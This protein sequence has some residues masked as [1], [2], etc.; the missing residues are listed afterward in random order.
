[1]PVLLKYAGVKSWSTF[2]RDMLLWDIKEDAGCFRIESNS[3]RPNGMWLEDSEQTIKFA[4]ETSVDIII[5]RVIV[6]LQDATRN[7]KT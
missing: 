7:M 2:E 3:K 6:I 4:P 1:P 5:D